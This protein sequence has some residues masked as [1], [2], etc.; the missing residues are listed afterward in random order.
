MQKSEKILDEWRICMKKKVVLSLLLAVTL[1]AQTPLLAY[2][3]QGA[4]SVTPS[5][6]SKV[7]D[8][9]IVVNADGAPGASASGEGAELIITGNVTSEDAGGPGVVAENKA[10]VEV[11]GAVSSENEP[12]VVANSNATVEVSGDVSSENAPG[13]ET[14]N[15]TV[16]VSGNVSSENA[17]GV[18]A[19]NNATL[20]VSSD[21]SSTSE[22]AVTVRDNSSV[23]VD[24]N[25]TGGTTKDDEELDRDSSGVCVDNTSTI[26]VE[27]GTVSSGL[28][29]DPVT[30][31]KYN[32]A[33]GVDIELKDKDGGGKIVINKIVSNDYFPIWIGYVRN[34]NDSIFYEPNTD[35]EMLNALP[36]IIVGEIEAKRE[37]TGYIG[38]EYEGKFTENEAAEAEAFHKKLLQKINY[39]I[40]VQSVEN[41]SIDVEGTEV[42]EGYKVAKA[43]QEIKIKVTANDGYEITSVSGGKAAAVKNADGTYTI[44]VVDGGGIDISAVIRAIVKAEA[45]KEEIRETVNVEPPKEEPKTIISNSVSGVKIND[46]QDVSNVLETK[47]DK[48]QTLPNS[49]VKMLALELPK[50]KA[51]IPKNVVAS[52][53]KSESVWLH[54]FVGNGNAVTFINNN[55]I[56]NYIPT[57]FT[58]KETETKNIKTIEFAKTQSIGTT[59]FFSTRVKVKNKPV[60]VWEWKNGQFVVLGTFTTT[61]NG[62]LAFPITATGRYAITY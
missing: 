60:T 47:K 17:P 11:T 52:V 18:V 37:Y 55:T 27:K 48:I 56:A 59:V 16:E 4:V 9:N 31:E 36:T 13:V 8:D 6:E 38:S 35:N 45:V 24:G 49:D 25:V 32:T 50:N 53:K 42:V 57:D 43:G 41:G 7:V 46:W 15:A 10:K 22:N 61:E 21:V 34:D 29:V 1:S 23:T 28:K 20:T 33:P 51:E 40:G 39:L 14:N 54:C 30:D 62:N 58:L 26:I 44:T 2:A 5:D 12:G 19:E 3:E